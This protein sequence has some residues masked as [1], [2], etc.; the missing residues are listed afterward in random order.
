MQKY[1]KKYPWLKGYSSHP[2]ENPVCSLEWLP[3]GWVIAF[4]DEM[5][6]ELDVVLRKTGKYDEAYVT[7]AKEKYGSLRLYLH[8]FNTEIEE[9]ILKYEVI[10]AHVC[11]ICGAVDIPMLN[12]GGWFS[13]CCK[14]CYDEINQD[15]RFKS[16]EEIADSDTQIP[17]TI[18]WRRYSK[19]VVQDFEADISETVNK[20]REKA[21]KEGR[22]FNEG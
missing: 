7:E 20:I 2:E 10:S 4:G 22:C 3:K 6:Q 11:E 19:G 15:N 8:P 17:N 21:K 1:L 9:I 5:C 14:T 18:K 12:I 16:F 13:P